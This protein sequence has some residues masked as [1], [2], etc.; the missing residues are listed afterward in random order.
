[1][2]AAREWVSRLAATVGEEPSNM[3]RR[4]GLATTTLTRALSPSGHGKLTRSTLEALARAYGVE[5]PAAVLEAVEPGRRRRS[6]RPDVQRLARLPTPPAGP[7]DVPVWGAI[8]SARPGFFHLNH[9]ALDY[10]RRPPG[11]AAV[12]HLACLR[13]PD[14]SMA[15]WRLAG[16]AL[17]LDPHRPMTLMHHVLVECAVLADPNGPTL[18]FV[19]QLRREGYWQHAPRDVVALD[20]LQVVNRVRVLEWQELLG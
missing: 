16:E 15:P 17:Y 5:V 9:V 13:M 20:G 4:A 12:A 8:D 10:A 6:A 3:A 14:D 7:N 18:S 11:A 19:A 2:N 1:M